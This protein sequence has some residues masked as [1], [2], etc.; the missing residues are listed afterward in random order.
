LGTEKREVPPEEKAGG[1]PEEKAGGLGD[2]KKRTVFFCTRRKKGTRM[3][4]FPSTS[5]F[6]EGKKR[7]LFSS[8]SFPQGKEGFF[9]PPFLSAFFFS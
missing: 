4:L 2:K 8:S 6:P 5:F 9:Y 3:Y 7:A 1:P